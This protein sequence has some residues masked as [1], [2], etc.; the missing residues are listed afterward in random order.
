MNGQVTTTQSVGG[1]EKVIRP[2]NVI[3]MRRYVA[4]ALVTSKYSAG[5]IQQS[6]TIQY[7]LKDHLGSTDVIV[8]QNGV[9]VNPNGGNAIKQQQSFDVWGQRRNA[10]NWQT[11]PAS[12]LTAF[13]HSVTSKGFTGHEMVDEVGIIHMNGRIYDPKIGRF[14]QADPLVQSPRNT[15]SYNRYSY[16]VNNPLGLVDPSG[17]KY[18]WLDDG[19]GWKQIVGV[20]IT[21]VASYFCAGTCTSSMWAATMAA[22]GAASAAINGGNIALGALTGAIMGYVGGGNWGEA[23]FGVADGLAI[24]TAGGVTSMLDGGNFGNGFAA[25]G[26]S[27]W[28]GYKVG[29]MKLGESG[30]GRVL[31]GAVIG[32]TI[33]ELTGGKFANGAMAG[34]F[35]AAVREGLSDGRLHNGDETREYVDAKVG[36]AATKEANEALGDV[37]QTTYSTKDVAAKAWS[38]AVR[39]V[40]DKYDTEIGSQIFRVKGGYQV[41]AA[42]SDGVIC[43]RGGCSV[44]PNLGGDVAGGARVGIV[45]THPGNRMFSDADL[46]TAARTDV[47]RYGG[48]QSVY[49]SLQNGQVWGWSSTSYDKTLPTWQDYNSRAWLVK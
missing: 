45:H 20:V 47:K 44:N 7:V 39:P 4:G 33:S 11:L 17:Y 31:A 15:Q 21:A 29:G 10:T 18:T 41:G 23:G 8:D 2:D 46:N 36:M 34:A 24:A 13:D 42:H 9:V 25:A 5:G 3:E 26:L 27:A 35:S 19:G 37:L 16:V 1:I 14:L 22:A 43:S 32:G 40:A 30:L 38:G 48:P 28:A 49:V 6:S 12:A